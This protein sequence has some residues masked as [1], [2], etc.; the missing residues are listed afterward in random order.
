MLLVG[1]Q[2]EYQCLAPGHLTLLTLC[3]MVRCKKQ[4]A[5]INIVNSIEIT[6]DFISVKCDSIFFL[7]PVYSQYHCL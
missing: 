3:A 7:I 5:N 4:K 1:H 6:A 2:M